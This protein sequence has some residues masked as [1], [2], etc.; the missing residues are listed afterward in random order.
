MTNF[1]ILFISFIIFIYQNAGKDL[2]YQ[3]NNGTTTG[4]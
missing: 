1:I 4:S 2:Y 3:W